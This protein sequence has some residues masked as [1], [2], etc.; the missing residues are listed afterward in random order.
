M[1]KSGKGGGGAF[2]EFAFPACPGGIG[3]VRGHAV[4]VSDA[5]LRNRVWCQ[6]LLLV[7]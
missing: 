4:G 1:S 3:R 7:L 6:A 2:I 5:C